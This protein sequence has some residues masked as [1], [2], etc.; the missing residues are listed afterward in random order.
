MTDLFTELRTSVIPEIHGVVLPYVMDI[1]LDSTTTGS[2]GGQIK[3][4]ETVQ[5]AN[6]PCVYKERTRT[7]KGE[8]A[9]QLRS[10]TEYEM[11]FPMYH[12][13]TYIPLDPH[14]R[15]KVKASGDVPAL[16]FRITGTK[17]VRGVYYKAICMIEN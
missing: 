15:L 7:Q 1:V 17:S 10:M 9:N 5:F 13:S 14:Y 12:A 2:G 8:V 11:T 4:A 3:S 16:T 6:V